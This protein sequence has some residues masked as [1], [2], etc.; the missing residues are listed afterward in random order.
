M[1]FSAFTPLLEFLIFCG[2]NWASPERKTDKSDPL[3]LLIRAED[4]LYI[5]YNCGVGSAIFASC[6]HYPAS[7]GFFP[8][9]VLAITVFYVNINQIRD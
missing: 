3:G 5:L 4:S 1:I 9:W 8:A 7:R 6:H 2:T